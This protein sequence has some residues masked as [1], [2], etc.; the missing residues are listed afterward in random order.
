M[1]APN[2]DCFHLSASSIAAFKACPTRFRLS[3][4]EGIRKDEDTDAQRVGTS[5]HAMHE[6]HHNALVDGAPR[7]SALAAVIDYLDE[8]YADQTLPSWKTIEEWELERQILLTCFI[9]YQ[10][11][12]ENDPVTP[13]ISELGF[14]LPVTDPLVGL[15]LPKSKALRVGKIDHVVEWQGMIG[16]VE[17]KSTTRKIE[18]GSEYW[19]KSQKDTQVSMYALAFKDLLASG[20]MPQP[21][22]DRLED[23]TIR[24]GNT[25]YDVWHKPTI[26]PSKLSQKD[27]LALIES[28]IYME[29]HFEV[30]VIRDGDDITAIL[31]D[32]VEAEFVVGKSGNP[33]V[34]ETIGMFAARL[35]TDIQERPDFYFQRKEIA[36]TTQD[37]IKFRT[38][39]FNL[40]EAQRMFDRTGCWYENENQCRATFTCPYIP[41]C[42]GEGADA[43]CDGETTPPGFKRIFVDLTVNTRDIEE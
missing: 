26:K 7:D 4:R 36:R 23:K 37:L 3:Y 6:V 16:N 9:G 19:E 40:Y 8:R 31:I 20:E 30:E 41:I 11:V 39:L 22:L 28:G 33:A 24:P 32:E 15:P 42:Y 13:I 38:E 12:W 14:K 43:V 18:P 27:T 10:W 29:D 17:R 25:L 34:R 5:W 2:P 35:M 1:A 21:V